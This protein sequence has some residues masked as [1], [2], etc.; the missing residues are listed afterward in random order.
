ML[1]LE[2]TTKHKVQMSKFILQ[3]CN[4]DSWMIGNILLVLLD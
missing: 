1:N 3:I 4:F 2:W